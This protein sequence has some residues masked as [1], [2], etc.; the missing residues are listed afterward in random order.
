MN[1]IVETEDHNDKEDES[2]SEKEMEE[3]ETSESGA[4]NIINAQIK[5]I[6]LTYEILDLNANLPQVYISDTRLTNIQDAKLHRTKPSKGMG[7]TAGKSSVTILLVENKEAKVNLDEGKYCTCVGKD[8]FKTVIPDWEEK[9]IPIQ[10]VKFSCASESTK[11]LGRIELILIFPH[12][13]KCI[14]VEV[15]FVVMDNCISNHFILGNDHLLV[16]GIDIS[17]QKGRDFTI[18]DN[19]RQKFCFLINK[20][21]ITAIKMKRKSKRNIPS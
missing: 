19:R 12:P 2:E 21:Q 20:K 5:N 18:G 17:N 16:Y 1:E 14:R 6:D 9:L 7:Y 11:P 13:S 10:G 4:I 15:E 8:Y 3:S